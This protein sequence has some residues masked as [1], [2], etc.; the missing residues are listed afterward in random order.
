ME[1]VGLTR[2]KAVSRRQ[3]IGARSCL[4]AT[5]SQPNQDL[6]RAPRPITRIACSANTAAA[7]IVPAASAGSARRGRGAIISPPGRIWRR[8]RTGSFASL[9]SIRMRLAMRV[10]H[11]RGQR[12]RSAAGGSPCIRNLFDERRSLGT[13][14]GARRIFNGSAASRRSILPAIL[15]LMADSPDLPPSRLEIGFL[16]DSRSV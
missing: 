8:A 9:L 16:R 1:G 2:A 7:S 5:A 12:L 15:E 11:C 14:A 3:A 4:S 13:T 6:I 10:L